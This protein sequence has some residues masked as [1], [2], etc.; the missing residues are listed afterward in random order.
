M[1]F[2]LT[3]ASVL[4]IFRS[5]ALADVGEHLRILALQAVDDDDEP[6]NEML[7]YIR[8]AKPG[9]REPSEIWG[10]QLATANLVA[11]KKILGLYRRHLTSLH[12]KVL[13]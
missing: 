5:A 6:G 12:F 11:E 10:H 8:A 4:R 1:E 3:R 13:G 7:E 9:D 2:Y